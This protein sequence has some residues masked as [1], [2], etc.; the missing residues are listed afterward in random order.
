MTYSSFE[1][2]VGYVGNRLRINAGQCGSMRINADQ[3]VCVCLCLTGDLINVDG[4]FVMLVAVTVEGVSGVFREEVE[5]VD[6]FGG[7]VTGDSIKIDGFDFPIIEG[8]RDP[9]ELFND[10]HELRVHYEVI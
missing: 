6:H 4:G 7:D 9:V 10:G 2:F 5:L 1:W 3:I 8:F